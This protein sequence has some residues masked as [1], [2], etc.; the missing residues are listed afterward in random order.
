[1]VLGFELKDRLLIRRISPRGGSVPDQRDYSGV[2]G[3]YLTGRG[4]AC[5]NVLDVHSLV[6]ASVEDEA[7][8]PNLI[9]VHTKLAGSPAQTG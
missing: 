8:D 1:V 6:G 2:P 4:L 7:P 5:K 9:G 3:V